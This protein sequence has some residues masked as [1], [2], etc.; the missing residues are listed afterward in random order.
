MIFSV[1]MMNYINWFLHVKPTMHKPHSLVS[2]SLWV[3]GQGAIL[4]S[5]MLHTLLLLISLAVLSLVLGHVPC[6]H[7]LISIQLS[8]WGS[9]SGQSWAA[10]LQIFPFQHPG[11]GSLLI[12]SLWTWSSI[13]QLRNTAR[14]PSPSVMTWKLPLGHK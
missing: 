11:L 6:P 10:S 14:V 1:T 12:L 2:F 9:A 13:S 8:P 7:A 4:C 3:L 5:C